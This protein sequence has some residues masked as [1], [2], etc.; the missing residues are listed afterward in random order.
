MNTA[1]ASFGRSLKYSA[2]LFNARARPLLATRQNLA[3]GAL[4]AEGSPNHVLHGD[5]EDL[6]FQCR[7]A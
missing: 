6:L 4:D 1:K 3:V 7:S 2:Y 5:C